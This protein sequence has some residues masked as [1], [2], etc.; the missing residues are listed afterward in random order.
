MFGAEVLFRRGLGAG[1]QR[2]RLR[3]STDLGLL[4]GERGSH[5]GEEFLG[6]GGVDE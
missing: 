3:A 5:L 2:L 6:D 1:H 4:C